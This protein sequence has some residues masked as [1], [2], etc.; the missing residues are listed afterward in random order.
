[1]ATTLRPARA[2]A[3]L[4]VLITAAV[5]ASSAS[6]QSGTEDAPYKD[7][8]VA[9]EQRPLFPFGFELSYTQFELGEP[10]LSSTRIAPDGVVPRPPSNSLSARMPSPIGTKQ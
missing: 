5:A 8:A 4:A 1:M 7:P 3:L 6:A 9:V 2:G 10:K